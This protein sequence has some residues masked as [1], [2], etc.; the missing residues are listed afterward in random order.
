MYRDFGAGGLLILTEIEDLMLAFFIF[1]AGLTLV[2]SCQQPA[3]S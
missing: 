3:E 1:D 2:A